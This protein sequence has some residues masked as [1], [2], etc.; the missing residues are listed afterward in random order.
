MMVFVL[1]LSNHEFP[2]FFICLIE[3]PHSILL[4]PSFNQNLKDLHLINNIIG[5]VFKEFNNNYRQ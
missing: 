2:L 4:S 3:E 5:T 1:P